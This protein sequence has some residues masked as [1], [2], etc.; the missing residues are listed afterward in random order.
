[1]V[2]TVVT[3]TCSLYPAH[4]ADSM[5]GAEQCVY[6]TSSDAREVKESKLANLRDK[7]HNN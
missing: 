1:M 5:G 6:Q 7:H 2:K 4:S 3:T